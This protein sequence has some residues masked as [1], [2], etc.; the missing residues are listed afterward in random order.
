MGLAQEAELEVELEAVPGPPVVHPLMPAVALAVS[1]ENSQHQM[2]IFINGQRIDSQI[3][4]CFRLGR[5]RRRT[6]F[7]KRIAS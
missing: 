1:F 4:R 3:N 6:E 2:Y 5:C 7:R